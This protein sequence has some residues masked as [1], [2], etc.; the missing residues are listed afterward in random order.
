MSTI[1]R[2]PR[3]TLDEPAWRA[4]CETAAMRTKGCGLSTTT[5]SN[6]QFGDRRATRSIAGRTARTG[7]EDRT[8]MGLR[9]TG[10]TA[11]NP[12]LECGAWLLLAWDRVRLLSG[13]L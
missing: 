13:R 12:G 7:A 8:G 10:R 2:Y 9:N 3:S 1:A 11:G 6:F 5:T 4:L